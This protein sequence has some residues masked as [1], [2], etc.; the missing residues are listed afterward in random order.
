MYVCEAG[1]EQVD[2]IG[3][4]YRVKSLSRTGQRQYK[5]KT[6]QQTCFLVVTNKNS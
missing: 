2:A 6:L 1:T 3:A 4:T 5:T